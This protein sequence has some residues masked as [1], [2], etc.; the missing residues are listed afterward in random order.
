[1]STDEKNLSK[2]QQEFNNHGFFILKNCLQQD[3]ISQL[4]AGYEQIKP[5]YKTIHQ[6]L[7]Y[8]QQGDGV[9]HH[10]IIFGFPFLLFLEY[11]PVALLTRLFGGPCILNSYSIFDN[12]HDVYVRNIHQDSKLSHLPFPA[13]LNALIPLDTFT[14]DTGGTYIF[15]KAKMTQ[16]KPDDQTFFKEAKPLLPEQ[17]D[18]LFFDGYLWH[19]AGKNVTNLPRRAATL[20]FTRPFIKPQFDYCKALGYDFCS[21]LSENTKQLLGYNARIP[22]QLMEWYKP[23]KERFYKKNQY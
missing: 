2:Y 17:G 11:L 12:N 10:I 6:Q 16:T 21:S 5:V 23:V 1:M 7:N 19:C 22:S 4:A 18:I 15:P 9:C 3:I 14:P 8:H 20:T 13:M